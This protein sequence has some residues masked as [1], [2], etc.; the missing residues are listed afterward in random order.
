VTRTPSWRRY[1]HFWRHD[2][3]LD[4][5]DELAFHLDMRARDF[6]AR[7]MSADAARRAALAR[8]G[9]VDR[10]GRQLRDHDR[11]QQRVRNRRE[12]M[13]DVVQ[14]LRYALRALRRAPG[15]AAV[16][17]LTIALGIGAT[18]A[19]FSVVNALIL[20]PLPYRDADRI[21]MVWM[22]NTRMG[23]D[24]DIHSYPDFVDYRADST[25]LSGLAGFRY[26]AFNLTGS[27]APQR[28][29]GVATM[30]SLFSVLGVPPA[31]GRVYREEEEQDGRDGVVIVSH[32]FW[33]RALGADSA[34]LG[35]TLQM[36]GRPHTVIGVMPADF[37]F[38]DRD[39]DLWV[40]LVV[41]PQLQSARGTFWLRAIGRLAPGVS[42]EQAQAAL[43][44]VASRLARDYPQL[45]GYGVNVTSLPDEI[46]GGTVRTAL[47]VM[48][49]AVAAVLLIACANVANLLLSRAATREREIGVRVALGASRSR[50]VHQLLTESVLLAIVGGGAGIALA[51]AGLRALRRL[52]PADLP[53]IEQIA[54]DPTVLAFTLVLSVV[55]GV[56]FGLVPALQGARASLSDVLREGGGRGGTTGRQG[57][58][59]RRSLIGAQ[60]ALVVVLLT[61]A[62]LMI[63]SVI[64]MQRVD[65]GF[66]PDHLLTMRLQLPASRYDSAAKIS[67]F[68]DELLER[69]RALPLV[70]GAAAITDI[71]L[72]ET[73]NSTGFAIEGVP[74]PPA[75]ERVEVPVDVVTPDYF[76][77]MG[78]PLLQGRTFGP[79]DDSNAPQVVMI[80]SA[81][82][83]RYWPDGDAIG[84]RFSYGGDGDDAQWMT[85][86]GVVGDMRRTGFDRAVRYE[87]FL[88][89]SQN[90]ARSLTLVVRTTGTPSAISGSVREV[91]QSIDRDQPVFAVETMDRTLAGMVAER[92]FSMVLLGTFAALAL[93]L[94]VVGIYGVTA[95]LVAQRAR[96][97][98]VR[99]ALGAEPRSV[100][101]M[102]VRQGMTVAAIGLAAGVVGALVLTRLMT[103]LL[104]G[105]SATDATTF[106]AVTGVLLLVTVVA[107]YLPARRAA[108]ADPVVALRAE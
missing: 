80:N 107:N 41:P 30:A 84:K 19:I 43:A 105:V 64:E 88:P 56:L 68:Y 10:V 75:A 106:V 44:T 12:A 83:R 13:R 2:I 82:A 42:R 91:V 5:D 38:P 3:D 47:W 103:G 49:G 39:T 8:F 59:L 67:A 29:R 61:G 89:F 51:W 28:V 32:G 69:T 9:S 37:T 98:G 26:V 11:R 94:A 27:D 86:V 48:F 101:R 63:R 36:N 17:V 1:L 16:A 45:D 102:V 71:F 66:R 4:V 100:V 22:D 34:A 35:T 50:L 52:A 81:M 53:R 70:Q 33:T 78:I 54:I 31:L 79:Q 15:F 6:E 20:R 72:S 85:I 24:K 7:G 57:L 92:R 21:V 14:D 104:Y 40:P 87:T 93:V 96:E 23:I 99:I 97:I 46:V 58:R 108:R 76:Q 90:Q 62:G 25:A 55:T 18:T 77:V 74:L 65:L 73:P 95:Y 60:V